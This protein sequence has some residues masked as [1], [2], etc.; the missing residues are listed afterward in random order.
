MRAAVAAGMV[1]IGVTTGAVDA[2]ELL[3]AGARTTITS[4]EELISSDLAPGARLR[5]GRPR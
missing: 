2:G 4:L 3:E 1:P 5:G